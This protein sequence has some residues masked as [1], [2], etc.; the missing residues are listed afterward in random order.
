MKKYQNAAILLLRLATGINFLSAVASRLGLW[1][2]AAGGSNWQAFVAYTGQV[3]SLAPAAMIPFLA[4]IATALEIIFAILIIVGYK[5]RLAALGAAILTMLFALS[6]A[7]SFGVKS[8]M[9]YSVFVDSTSALLL[10]TM[11]YYKWSLDEK[12]NNNK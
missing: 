1:S 11:P 12:L 7:Y 8:A 5:T 4:V 3:N 2:K 6:M 9:D 10:A